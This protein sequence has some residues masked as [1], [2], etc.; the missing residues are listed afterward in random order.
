MP[1]SQTGLNGIYVTRTISS[2]DAITVP[3][4]IATKCKNGTQSTIGS[5]RCCQ[6]D[7]AF[8]VER[9]ARTVQQPDAL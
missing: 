1:L 2:A 9:R 3:G 8:F 5:Q 4:A 7:T 6:G